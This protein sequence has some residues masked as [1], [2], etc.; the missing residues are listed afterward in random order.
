MT[1]SWPTGEVRWVAMMLSS[2]RLP[3][4]A[5]ACTF[6]RQYRLSDILNSARRVSASPD[7]C[8]AM[9]FERVPTSERPQ[10]L[11]G[12]SSQRLLTDLA[13]SSSCFFSRSASSVQACAQNCA[14]RR[15]GS[16][17]PASSFSK[18]SLASL[19]HL[20]RSSG[21]L[22]RNTCWTIEK[23]AWRLFP[24]CSWND[25]ARSNCSPRCRIATN[26]SP[27]ACSSCGA[28]RTSRARPCTSQ[29]RPHGCPPQAA[30]TVL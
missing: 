11:W 24:S 29:A 8:S 6:I 2:S 28:S 12:P 19:S 23:A 13:S 1:S 25:R 3:A 27:T 20:A 7:S 15:S 26:T 9:S 21:S 16:G 17:A 18:Q 30:E 22:L 14:E 10:N 4:S 5:R